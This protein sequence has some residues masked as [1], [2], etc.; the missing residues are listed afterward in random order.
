M[1]ARGDGLPARTIPSLGAREPVREPLLLSPDG[2]YLYAGYGQVVERLWD[3]TNGRQIVALDT[4]YYALAF[5]PGSPEVAVAYVNGDLMV[6]RLPTFEVTDRWANCAG[7]GGV[8]WNASGTRLL[9][10]NLSGGVAVLDMTSKK[11]LPL[12]RVPSAVTAA[13]WH[14]NGECL[15]LATED[16]Y[17]RV[18]DLVNWT[19]FTVLARHEARIIRVLFLPPFPWILTSSW[20]GSSKLWDWHAGHELGRIEATGYDIQYEP[21]ESRV[22]WR[23][24]AEKSPKP[25]KLAGSEIRRQLFFGNPKLIGGPFLSCFGGHGKWL[26]APDTDALRVWHVDTQTEALRI[27]GYSQGI[28]MTESGDELFASLG[29]RFRHWKL[30]PISETCLSAQELPALGEAF[31]GS[32]VAGTQDAKVLGLLQGTSLKVWEN[33]ELHEWNHGQELAETLAVSPDGR[34]I[35]VGT[36]NHVGARIFDAHTG[37]LLWKTDVRHGTHPAFSWD[38][39]WLAIGTDRGCYLFDAR[40]GE[41][42]WRNRLTSDED[43]TFWEVAFS[44]DGKTLA[45]TSKTHR[46]QLLSAETGEEILTL[47]YPT[48][49]FITGLVFSADG[50]WLSETSN[51]HTIQLWDLEAMRRQLGSLNLG[52]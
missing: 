25:W 16:G 38:S 8:E 2:R 36:R 45:W 39:Q 40:H 11:F 14:P 20:D 4:N 7:E 49:R 23:L 51:K 46:I 24:G 34:T 42:R 26:A 41:L 15:A 50:R 18:Q 21:E 3:L 44:P 47:D 10:S 37:A 30:K 19:D 12:P 33:G 32:K 5:R 27:P 28:W 43:P 52:W 48:P 1:E 13:A 9:F 29:G 35:A 31:E 22:W 17:V 6:H